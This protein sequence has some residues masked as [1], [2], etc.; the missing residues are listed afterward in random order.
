MTP[1]TLPLG[2]NLYFGAAEYTDRLVWATEL[3]LAAI[4][5]VFPVLVLAY[6]FFIVKSIPVP[7]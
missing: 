2:M 3:S 6:I 4:G 5:L 7:L 1:Y